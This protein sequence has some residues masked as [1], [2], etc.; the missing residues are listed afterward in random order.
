MP[1]DRKE[2]GSKTEELQN[3]KKSVFKESKKVKRVLETE[4]KQQK[5]EKKFLHVEARSVYVARGINCEREEA[6][7]IQPTGEQLLLSQ[8]IL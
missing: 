7:A 1:A 4:E 3:Q 2:S 6:G 5:S 8:T